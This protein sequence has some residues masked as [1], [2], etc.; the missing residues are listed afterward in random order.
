MAAV[1]NTDMSTAADREK[2]DPLT[3]AGGPSTGQ[4]PLKVRQLP[5]ASATALLGVCPEN[6]THMSIQK[7]LRERS[8]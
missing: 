1:I 4:P 2:P 3:L 6:W 5:H 8:E 7:L